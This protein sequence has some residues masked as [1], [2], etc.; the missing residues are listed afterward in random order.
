ML[1]LLYQIFIFYRNTKKTRNII[2]EIETKQ[3]IYN[4]NALSI[5]KKNSLRD[6]PEVT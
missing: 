6:E 5:T 2:A 1:S 4:E 3:S